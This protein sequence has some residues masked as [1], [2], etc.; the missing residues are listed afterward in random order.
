MSL[1]KVVTYENKTYYVKF[2]LYNEEELNERTIN[3][4]ED[5]LIVIAR[6]LNSQYKEVYKIKERIGLSD[7]KSLVDFVKKIVKA[8]H[9]K[10]NLEQVKL[11]DNWNGNM[12]MDVTYNVDI[13]NTNKIM[14]GGIG[15]KLTYN[16]FPSNLIMNP[17]KITMY[18]V[19]IY[20]KEKDGKDF[21]QIEERKAKIEDS[22]DVFKA[23]GITDPLEITKLMNAA[24]AL[25]SVGGKTAEEAIDEFSSKLDW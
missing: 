16:T 3:K 24:N 23:M 10:N 19:T 20:D 4:V 6:V 12:D 1:E 5:K 18:G 14:T 7:K 11:F 8:A 2:D 22:A 21:S 13:K 9:T 25:K 17:N 15:N